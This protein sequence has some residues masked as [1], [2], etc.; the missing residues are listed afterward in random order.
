MD[1]NRLWQ[2]H[3]DPQPWWSKW[4]TIFSR[5]FHKIFN[6]GVIKAPLKHGNK[7]LNN[8]C[9]S[10][11]MF[12]R[13]IWDKFTEFTFLHLISRLHRQYQDYQFDVHCKK[14]VRLR[15]FFGLYIPAFGLIASYRFW[16]KPLDHYVVVVIGFYPRGN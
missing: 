9:T 4:V 2:P 11:H 7:T 8:V 12:K 5:K 15:S 13:E 14:S 10:N 16:I 3:S 6:T 1:K